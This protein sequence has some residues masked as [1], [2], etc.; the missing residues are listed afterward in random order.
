MS[1]AASQTVPDI[2]KAIVFSVAGHALLLGTLTVSNF[3]SHRGEIWGGPGGGAVT[4][5]LVSGVTG[6]T[7]PRPEAM[8]TSRV[9]DESKGLY[10]SEP[11]PKQPE[12]SA[13]K[14]PEFE[15]NKQK[16]Y[17][18]RPSRVF[19]DTTPPPTGAIP[20][21][22][23]GTPALPYTQFTVGASQGGL[24]FSGPGGGE[25]AGRFPWYVDA[26]RRRIS[27]NWVQSYVDPTVRWAP[28]AVIS[29][30][31][32]R[33]GTILNIQIL[34]SS[35]N[36]SVDRS[37]VRAIRESSPLERLP[38]EYNGSFVMVEFWFDFRR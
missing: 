2:K 11:K 22:Q 37:A 21:G 29:F 14:I 10:K 17:I 9:V 34:K 6:I 38:S 35:G 20:Y 16:K 12:E 28:R 30:Q 24:G 13:T 32:Q 1:Y 27:S 5:G 31:V 33:D 4:V 25:F 36:D 3:L 18:T 23:G 8:T 7:L 19:E 26:V 15:K